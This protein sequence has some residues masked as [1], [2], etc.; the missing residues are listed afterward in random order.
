MS[1]RGAGG[2]AVTGAGGY[3]PLGEL[4]FLSDC[5]T[6]ALMGP[7]AAVKWMCAPR[8]DAPSVFARLLDRRVGGAWELTVEGAGAPRRW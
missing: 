1:G 7:D 4:A 5:G 6:A 3:P 2:P 8:Y